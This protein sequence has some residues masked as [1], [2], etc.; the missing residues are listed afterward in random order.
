[1]PARPSGKGVMKRIR[2][3]TGRQ[4]HSR[5]YAGEG[6][7]LRVEGSSA[8]VLVAVGTDWAEERY[9]TA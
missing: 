9:G 2:Y 1:V 6:R 7:V 8:A 3:S 5:Q 4:V